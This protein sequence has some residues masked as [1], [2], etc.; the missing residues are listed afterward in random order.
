MYLLTECRQPPQVHQRQRQVLRLP[1]EERLC[2]QLPIAF[3]LA[4]QKA[5]IF[6]TGT[7]QLRVQRELQSARNLLQLEVPEL[8][9]QVL[10]QGSQEDLRR[11]QVPRSGARQLQRWDRVRREG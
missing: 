6:W 2:A 10:R 7:R 3:A 4:A 5:G 11:G 8:R 9:H 1:S